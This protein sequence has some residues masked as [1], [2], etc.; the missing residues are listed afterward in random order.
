MRLLILIAICLLSL[1]WQSGLAAQEPDD[2]EL[3]PQTIAEIRHHIRDL[4]ADSFEAREAAQRQLWLIGPSTAPFLEDAAK[5]GS[6]EVR[7]RA[8]ALLRTIQR[9]PLKLAIETFCSRPQ[10]MLDLEQGMWLISRIGNPKLKLKDLTRQYDEIAAQVREKLGKDVDPAQADPEKVVAALREVIFDDLKFNSNKEDYDNPDNCFPERVLATRKGRPVFVAHVVVAVARR[11]DVPIVGL[12]VSGMYSL[13]Y[14]GA[15]A[16]K[17]FSRE[18][19]VFYPHDR[20]RVLSP[21]EF[22][23]LLGAAGPD[24]LPK[25]ASPRLALVR[26]LS[27]LTSVLDHQPDRAEEL[28]LANEMLLRLKRASDDE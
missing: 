21:E 5:S 8:E 14:D 25:P 18:D 23:R 10:E 20:G 24:S 11:L 3:T 16:P 2:A 1:T 26:M 7:F 27:N 13:K 12:P 22:P 19:I 9:G 28:Q 6:P 17:R 4:D 15:K